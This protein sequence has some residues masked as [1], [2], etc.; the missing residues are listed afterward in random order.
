MNITN[1]KPLF[2]Y[3]VRTQGLNEVNKAKENFHLAFPWKLR[4]LLKPSKCSIISRMS[5][6]DVCKLNFVLGPYLLYNL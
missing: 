6:K 4:H 5:S 3:M 2:G 1:T